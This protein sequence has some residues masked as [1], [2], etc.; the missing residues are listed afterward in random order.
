MASQAIVNMQR[1]IISYI[2][3]EIPKDTNRAYFGYVK[4]KRVI[5]GNRSYKY[6]P[7]TDIYFSNGDRV[8]CI[9]PNSG[10]TAAVVGVG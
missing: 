5:I 4:G 2:N 1:A 3:S 10:N 7:V 9:L 8:A 6:D